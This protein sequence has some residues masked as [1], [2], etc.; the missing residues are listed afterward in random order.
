[1]LIITPNFCSTCTSL[2]FILE[3]FRAMSSRDIQKKI[4]IGTLRKLKG[5]NSSQTVEKVAQR[6]NQVTENGCI[7]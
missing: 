3:L 6:F 4:S 5:D 2:L 1:M 7:W